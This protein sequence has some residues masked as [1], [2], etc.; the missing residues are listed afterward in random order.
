MSTV[1]RRD[2][3]VASV[4]STIDILPAYNLKWQFLSATAAS[5]NLEFSHTSAEQH[6]GKHRSCFIIA[7]ST[8]AGARAEPQ[9]CHSLAVQ[10]FQLNRHPTLYLVLV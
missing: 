5:C 9:L 4:L 1:T 8:T 10:N 7:I 3:K 2:P 6:S